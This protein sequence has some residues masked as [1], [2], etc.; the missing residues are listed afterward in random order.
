MTV[1]A[2]SDT[3]RPRPGASHEAGDAASL[4]GAIDLVVL[5]ASA[6][7]FDALMSIARQ[8][9]ADFAPALVAVLH[10]PAHQPSQMASLLGHACA[11]PVS[12]AVDKAPLRA[13]TMVVAPPDYHLLIE[14]NRRLSLSVDPPVLH[15]RPAI[16]PLFESAAIAFGPRLLGIVLTGASA[17]GSAG[18]A[19]VRRRGG[20]AWVQSPED[21]R[22]SIMPASALATA[23]ADAVL[24][25]TQIGRRLAE[26][27]TS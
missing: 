21:A 7:G 15:S 12:E 17:D 4:R 13:G 10:L 8:L 18:L 2:R 3:M 24:T 1:S 16:D 27:R 25:L 6:G 20:H 14:S 26:L 19:A 22:V 5:G 23:G 11:V 9:P